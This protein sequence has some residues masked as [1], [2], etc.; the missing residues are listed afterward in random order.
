[1]RHSDYIPLFSWSKA[2]K[3]GMREDEGILREC[4]NDIAQRMK[5]VYGQ[6]YNI[7]V[8]SRMCA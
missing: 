8:V 3:N 7:Y 4:C 1:M 2:A 6:L 5:D